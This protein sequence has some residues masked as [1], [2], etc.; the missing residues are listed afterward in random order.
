MKQQASASNLRSGSTTTHLTNTK[1]VHTRGTNALIRMITG[2]DQRCAQFSFAID[3]GSCH[4][5]HHQMQARS[6]AEGE[7]F[8]PAAYTVLQFNGLNVVCMLQCIST[9]PNAPVRFTTSSGRHQCCTACCGTPSP[10]PVCD[11]SGVRFVVK[12]Y[13]T[14]V[15]HGTACCICRQ[16]H[17]N[18]QD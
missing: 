4:G 18:R 13:H 1:T 9:H 17:A 7:A 2:Y 5:R 11:I 15:A 3:L 12:S 14:F 8:L 10:D 6:F 16:T